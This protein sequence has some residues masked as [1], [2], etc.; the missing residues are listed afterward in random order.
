[1]V[2]VVFTIA[3]VLSDLQSESHE[4][5]HLQCENSL[6]VN[7]NHYLCQR[8]ELEWMLRMT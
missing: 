8:N 4:Y 1:M 2:N 5:Q 6:R 3:P 7:K